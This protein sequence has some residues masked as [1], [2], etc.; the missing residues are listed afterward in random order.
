MRW[1]GMNKTGSGLFFVGFGVL[2]LVCYQI[3]PNKV[4]SC[5]CSKEFWTFFLHKTKGFWTPDAVMLYS[6]LISKNH[7]WVRF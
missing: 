4:L 2:G 5:E 7:K 1:A 3:V 6:Q